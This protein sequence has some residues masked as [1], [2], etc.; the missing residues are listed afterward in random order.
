MSKGIDTGRRSEKRVAKHMGARQHP[1]SGA[2]RGAK[3]DASLKEE[4]FQLEMKSTTTMTMPL[5]V[6]WLAKIS[7]EALQH[8]RRPAVVM[9]FTD[10]EGKARMRLNS[11]WVA[12]PMEVFKEL[13]GD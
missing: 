7:M 13:L 6:G 5:H 12:I 2:M 11:E 3:S 8:G 9:S 10:G 1:A 4:N